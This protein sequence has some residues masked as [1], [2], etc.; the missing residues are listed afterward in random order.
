MISLKVNGQERSYDGDPSMPL[1][2]F[3]R[4][5][6]AMPGTKFGCGVGLCGACTVHVDGGAVRSCSMQMS[7]VGGHSVVTIE[8]LDANGNHP[9]QRAW[10][11]VGVPQCG[12]CQSGQIMQAAALLT[13]VKNPSEAQ[14]SEAMAAAHGKDFAMGALVLTARFI[15][16]GKPLIKPEAR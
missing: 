13:K 5:E 2:W 4:D 8:G 7:E 6:L 12:Y 10:R 1:L 9:V 3:L 14:I 16:E 15:A 11:Q